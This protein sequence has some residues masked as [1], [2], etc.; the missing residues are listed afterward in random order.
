MIA[1]RKRSEAYVSVSVPVAQR[2]ARGELDQ[3]VA[4]LRRELSRIASTEDEEGRRF[5]Y[6]LL[7]VSH[8]RAGDPEGVLAVL[9]EMEE[10]LEDRPETWLEL[11]EGYLLLLGE[12]GPAQAWSG[13]A[14]DGL[15]RASTPA[16]RE[17]LARARALE[18]RAAL[19]AGETGE[20]LRILRESELPDPDLAGELLR[21]GVAA[22]ELRGTLRSGL[23]AHVAHEQ[24]GGAST[25]R[26][27]E[28]RRLLDRLESSEGRVP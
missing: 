9:R 12:A 25:A 8:S 19:L 22:G 15:A 21:A 3:A 2:V 23:A 14:R 7:A 28:I 24:L 17:G 5:L 16:E 4:V 11:A 10:T 6:G 1:R 20:A 13:R 27:Q 18:G 26:S